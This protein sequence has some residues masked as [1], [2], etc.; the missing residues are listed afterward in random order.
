MWLIDIILGRGG[1]KRWINS[2]VCV[3]AGRYVGGGDLPMC[4][5]G[6]LANGESGRIV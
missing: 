2:W 4:V 1:K 6:Y 3:Y 5:W